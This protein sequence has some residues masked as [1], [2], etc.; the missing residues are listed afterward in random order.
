MKNI[1]YFFFILS[2]FSFFLPFSVFAVTYEQCITF[3]GG[4]SWNAGV[5]NCPS[6]ETWSGD[7]CQ[8]SCPG[9]NY[10][11]QNGQCVKM[12]N[13]NEAQTI[14]NCSAITCVPECDWKSKQ[15][16]STVK[17]SASWDSSLGECV[18]PSGFYSNEASTVGGGSG[19]SGGTSGGNDSGGSGSSGGSSTTITTTTSSSTI[20]NPVSYNSFAEL[21]N[22]VITWIRNI[23]FV[24]A[25]LMIVY[26]GFT[27]MTAM[28][29]SSKITKAKHI[30]LYAAIGLLVALL[31]QSLLEVISGFT[32]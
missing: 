22:A 10:V 27:Y 3:G 16:C 25:P 21:L 5:C 15:T 2:V 12:G 4:S 1:K 14:K 26:A 32:K 11:W 18:C 8:H 19:S 20:T 6:G 29:D 28:G 30:I 17:K 7:S 31:A 13:D 24:V 9:S 23:A